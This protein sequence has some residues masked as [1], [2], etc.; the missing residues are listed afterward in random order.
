LA[1]ASHLR[2]RLCIENAV[3]PS[4][5]NKISFFRVLVITISSNYAITALSAAQ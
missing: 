2:L 4:P 1:A 5:H 3:A